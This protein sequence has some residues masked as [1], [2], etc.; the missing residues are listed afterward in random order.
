MGEREKWSKGGNIPDEENRICE[1]P[2]IQRMGSKLWRLQ[3]WSAK[4]RE[5]KIWDEAGEMTLDQT[6]LAYQVS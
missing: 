5:R 6:G 4:N 3:G 1:D 2:V